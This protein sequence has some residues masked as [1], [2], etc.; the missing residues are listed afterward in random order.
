[1]DYNLHQALYWY[2]EAA[3]KDYKDA[4][5][6][7]AQIQFAKGKELHEQGNS[8]QALEW[9]TQAADNG[10]TQAALMAAEL[11]ASTNKGIEQNYELAI[12]F[13][14][15]AGQKN[16]ADALNKLGLCYLLRTDAAPDDV[17]AFQC[18]EQA[19]QRGLAVAQYNLGN[20]YRYG[21]GT[22]PDLNKALVQYQQAAD[23][24]D[25][26]ARQAL[27]EIGKGGCCVLV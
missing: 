17:H 6:K 19:A 18:F 26:D 24:G 15:I 7:A 20:C 10:H 9:L 2:L 11:Y 8:F 3:K 21:K 4:R 23:Q 27:T 13:Y 12:K 16:N 1:M 22:K 25:E 5:E 14:E